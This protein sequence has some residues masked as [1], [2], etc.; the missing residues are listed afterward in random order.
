MGINRHARISGPKMANRQNKKGRS[1]GGQRFVQLHE[2]IAR[3][4]AWSRLSPTAKVAWMEIG[5]IYNGFNNGLL[6]VSSR[7]LGEKMD[8]GKSTA[9]RA[10]NELMRWGFLE[11]AKPSDFGKKKLA[12]EYR[13]THLHC[14]ATGLVAS[15]KFMRICAMKEAAE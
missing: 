13:L 5:L 2:Y 12:A 6:A 14:D 3:S 1:K 8:V 7:D 9:A 4:Y 11:M 15:K 10:I